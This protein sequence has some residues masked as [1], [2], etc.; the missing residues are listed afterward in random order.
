MSNAVRGTKLTDH[1]NRC[2]D[3][4]WVEVHLRY[5]LRPAPTG[6]KKGH[7]FFFFYCFKV[8]FNVSYRCLRLVDAFCPLEYSDKMTYAFH[9]PQIFPAYLMLHYLVKK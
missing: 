2:R 7:I 6:R 5:H 9:I 8:Q 1:P 3:E 4:E